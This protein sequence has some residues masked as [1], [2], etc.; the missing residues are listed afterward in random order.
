MH[1]II[2]FIL[3]AVEGWGYWGVF[4]LMVVESSFIPFPSE[5]I[6][7]PAGYLAYQGKM[8]LGIVILM[9]TLGSLVGA[10]INYYLSIFI[11]RAVIIK[12]G[13]YFL[14]SEDKLEKSEEFFKKHGSFSTFT[15]RLVPVIRQ[16]ISIPAGLSRMNI[17]KFSFF[18]S[19]G[20]GIWV[21]ILAFLGYFIGHNEELLKEY[22]K[23]IIITL[24]VLVVVAIAL[25]IYIHN[26]KSEKTSNKS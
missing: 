5:V 19:L 12:F 3:K 15:G 6:I 9:G 17:I 25:Y 20:A 1:E 11:G 4:V 23:I 26:K 8:N 24:L 2:Q 13:R 18:T 10:L 22:T 21:A 7:V 14:I 16:L